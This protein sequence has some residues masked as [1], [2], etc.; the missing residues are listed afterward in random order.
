MAVPIM[1]E[2]RQERVQGDAEDALLG[3]AAQE[4]SDPRGDGDG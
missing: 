1:L 4:E 3:E 2:I